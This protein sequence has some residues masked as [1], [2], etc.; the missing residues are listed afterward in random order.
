M[1]YWLA[2]IGLDTRPYVAAIIC[3]LIGFGQAEG[4]NRSLGS[5]KQTLTERPGWDNDPSEVAFVA[6]RCGAL[7]T[8]LG[9][10]LKENSSEP[11]DK[12]NGSRLIERGELITRS[13]FYMGMLV[14][15]DAEA[16]FHRSAELA[17]SYAELISSNKRLYNNVFHE[18]VRSDFEFCLG[19]EGDFIKIVELF[20]QAIKSKR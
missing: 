11:K 2:K 6:A 20:D 15:M 12:L 7:V 19:L 3:G 8:M 5:L 18:P 1:R 9:G 14:K 17:K 10:Y 16:S 4:S 13:G